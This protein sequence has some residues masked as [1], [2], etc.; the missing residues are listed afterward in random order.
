M[1]GDRIIKA[2]G[3]CTER[4]CFTSTDIL[5]MK[6]VSKALW[7]QV[8]YEFNKLK[9]K[10]ASRVIETVRSLANSATSGV[11]AVSGSITA[12]SFVRVLDAL[13]GGIEGK[14]FFDAGCG[15]GIPCLIAAYLG[16]RSSGVDTEKN[17]HVLSRIFM[18][19]RSRLGISPDKANIGFSDLLTMKYIPHDPQL[20]YTFW[21]GIDADARDNLLKMT[22]KCQTVSVFACT[23]APGETIDM[24]C[25][26]LNETCS[27]GQIWTFA[28]N[29]QVSAVGGM[30]RQVWIFKRKVQA[31]S[32]KTGS[33]DFPSDLVVSCLRWADEHSFPAQLRERKGSNGLSINDLIMAGQAFLNGG[34]SNFQAL[35]CGG[36]GRVFRAKHTACPDRPCVLKIGMEVFSDED[37]ENDSI[38]REYKTMRQLE[39]DQ[40]VSANLLHLFDGISA[41]AKINLGA[42]RNVSALCMQS[43]WGDGSSLK[44]Q[45]RDAFLGNGAQALSINC[46]L[47]FQK[48]LHLVSVLHEKR[49][50]HN[51]IKWSNILLVDEWL[52]DEDINM[53]LG[54][55]GIS[56]L[57]G[58]QYVTALPAS[59]PKP[60][61]QASSSRAEK[62]LKKAL[63]NAAVVASR[64]TKSSSKQKATNTLPLLTPVTD[65]MMQGMMKSDQLLLLSTGTPGYRNEAMVNLSYQMGKKP[66]K[67]IPNVKHQVDFVDVCKHDV[68]S[69][70][71]MLCEVMRE[72]SDGAWTRGGKCYHR[73]YELELNKLTKTQEVSDFLLKEKSVPLCDADKQTQ[74]LCKLVKDMLRSDSQQMSARE[75]ANHSFFSLVLGPQ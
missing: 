69:V 32:R 31:V 57:D 56:C 21:E 71:T 49:I 7:K 66:L 13:E 62:C 45:F 15:C 63:E 46:C 40:G 48:T 68:R 9:V 64:K 38:F 74:L 47:F 53:V 4:G 1:C 14:G 52:P 12:S 43:C 72:K 3:F 41:L 10:K 2:F 39:P 50:A 5:R 8:S 51:D 67:K 25:S 18:A 17:L 54:D 11:E 29:F 6:A 24:V 75:A 44:M 55:F 65:A 59:I 73:Q 30:Q 61:A 42:G 70:A 33:L 20:V 16:A 34:F 35:A 58:T 37:I 23:N 27:K 26:T 36:F 60:T 28:D 19:G 22:S